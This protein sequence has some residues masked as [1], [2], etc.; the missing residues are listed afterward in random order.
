MKN[1]LNKHLF[2]FKAPHILE[3]FTKEYLNE[4]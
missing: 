3:V 1:K 2:I 4:L